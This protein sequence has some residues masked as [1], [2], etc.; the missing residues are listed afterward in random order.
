MKFKI[1]FLFAFLASTSS[2][3]SPYQEK[4]QVLLGQG[5]TLAAQGQPVDAILKLE[6]SIVANPKNIT[7]YIELAR[8]YA[9]LDH[10]VEAEK[11]FEIALLLD[12]D[13]PLALARLGELEL[14]LDR[15]ADAEIRLNRLA[16][17][18]GVECSEYKS[19]AGAL[20]RAN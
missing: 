5:R 2:F 7:S 19:L 9:E 4:S 16:R 3:A 10:P 17:T 11:Y 13:S 12:P 8:L 6:Q 20:N 18:C 1:L 14:S 15:R